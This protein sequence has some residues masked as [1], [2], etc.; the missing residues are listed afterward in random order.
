[1]KYCDNQERI[2][3]Y[4][5]KIKDSG[6]IGVAHLKCM[7]GSC[8][9]YTTLSNIKSSN[10]ISAEK[11]SEIISV[12]NV[13]I[14]KEKVKKLYVDIYHDMTDK[15]FDEAVDTLISNGFLD[16]DKFEATVAGVAEF[17]KVLNEHLNSPEYLAILNTLK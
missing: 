1:M 10:L 4:L 6:K 12:T 15:E 3:R 17:K 11:V 5:A 8:S 7:D 16:K 9:D 13:K 14:D 2:L